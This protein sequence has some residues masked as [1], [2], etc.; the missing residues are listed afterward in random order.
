[1]RESKC[2]SFKC[3]L[4][5]THPYLSL[6][7]L[8]A[9]ELPKS[10]RTPIVYLRIMLMLAFSSIFGTSG[11]FNGLLEWL[12]EVNFYLI[13]MPFF[14]VIPINILFEYLI[15]NPPDINKLSG[16]ARKL[17]KIK[18]GLGVFLGFISTLGAFYAIWVLA[19]NKTRDESIS[20]TC[21]FVFIILQDMMLMPLF[22]ILVQYFMIRLVYSRGKPTKMNPVKKFM[23]KF[24]ID[25][26]LASVYH[27]PY[28]K[29]KK[30]I[31]KVQKRRT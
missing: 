6:F 1:M 30:A 3:A 18:Y 11:E 26:R 20:W 10:T 14:T 4:L 17:V 8:Y 25:K 15:Q 24:A 23:I 21:D 12:L 9:P 19:A 5:L 29:K 7:Y 31:K 13:L 28:D 22:S 27:D 16:P 2:I